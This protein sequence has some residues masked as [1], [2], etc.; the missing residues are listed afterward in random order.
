MIEGYETEKD[1]T[2]IEGTVEQFH[3]LEEKEARKI[4]SSLSGAVGDKV[5]NLAN[6]NGMTNFDLKVSFK[7]VSRR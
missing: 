7:L 3:D 4:F 2:T 6:R 5:R 1:I